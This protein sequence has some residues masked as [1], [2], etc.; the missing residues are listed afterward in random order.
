MSNSSAEE[1]EDGEA[2]EDSPYS[3]LKIDVPRLTDFMKEFLQ[4]LEAADPE[5]QVLSTSTL[6]DLKGKL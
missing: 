4:T 3:D 1:G 2:V 6:D 5:H